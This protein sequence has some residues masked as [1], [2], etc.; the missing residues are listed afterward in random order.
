MSEIAR[1]YQY[2]E[3]LKTHR[4]LS[5]QQLQQRLEVSKAT[6]TRDMAKLRYQ[7]NTPI[8]Y[9]RDLGG[10]CLKNQDGTSSLPGV[11]FSKEE[12]LA[13]LTIQS[14]LDTLEPGLLGAKLRPLRAR[15]DAMLTRQGLDPEELARRVR[16]VHAGKRLLEMAHFETVAKAT[17]ERK[18]LAVVHF[19]R[20][21]GERTSREIS[22]QQLVHYRDN[23]YVDAVCHLRKDVRSFAVDAIESAQ[24]LATAADELDSGLLRQRMGAAYGIFGGEPKAWARLR[25][26]AMRARWVQREQWH[27]Q[28]KMQTLPD[29]GLELQVPY[30]DERELIGDILRFGADVQVM[31]PAALK[32]RYGATLRAMLA[33]AA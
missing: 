1:L 11:Y 21:R 7:L 8:A 33:Q 22:P 10:Y 6:L 28:Q 17:I 27:P 26:S 13:L 18:R 2:L 23:W 3:L 19:N 30:S 15:L 4:S 32:K 12:L 9:D 25:F 31:A 24:M 20:E 16:V 29:G 14:M 5:G